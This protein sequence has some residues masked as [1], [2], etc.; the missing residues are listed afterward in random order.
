MSFAE[1][2]LCIEEAFVPL[3][4]L[5]W[6][7]IL[8]IVYYSFT[9]RPWC[10]SS[11]GAQVKSSVNGEARGKILSAKG[12]ETWT[13]GWRECCEPRSLPEGLRVE[14][15]NLV[16]EKIFLL[17]SPLLNVLPANLY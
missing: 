4:Q 17:E 9:S 11:L 10:K 7:R 16:T 8:A 2:Q 13:A 15:S 14:G 6:V 1:R 3:N 5:S 12:S